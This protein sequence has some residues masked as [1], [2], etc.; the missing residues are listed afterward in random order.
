[1]QRFRFQMEKK[2]QKITAELTHRFGWDVLRF[3]NFS[4]A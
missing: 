2:K 3:D 4:F 1:M